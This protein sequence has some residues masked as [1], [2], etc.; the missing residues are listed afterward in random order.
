VSAADGVR[1]ARILAELQEAVSNMHVVSRQPQIVVASL[2]R[3]NAPRAMAWQVLLERM[4]GPRRPTLRYRGVSAASLSVI[5]A[6][7]YDDEPSLDRNWSHPRLG[8][9]MAAGPV[10]QVFR[11]DRLPDDVENALVGLLV[12]EEDGM[13]LD[14]VRALVELMRDT[15]GQ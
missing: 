13:K 11:D 2:T 10:I 5:I 1:D 9:A 8:D 6:R 12:F 3:A 7:G 14:G 15:P 4:L